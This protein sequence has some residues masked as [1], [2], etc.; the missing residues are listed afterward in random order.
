MCFNTKEGCDLQRR[1]RERDG[2]REGSGLDESEP[3]RLLPAEEEGDEG[4][5]GGAQRLRPELKRIGCRPPAIADTGIFSLY[6]QKKKW[7]K[8][9]TKEGQK[10]KIQK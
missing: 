8:I 7:G 10:R 3:R 1:E 2:K 6:V 5:E 4:E 9:G